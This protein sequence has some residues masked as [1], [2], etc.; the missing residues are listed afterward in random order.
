MG[1]HTKP[2]T[3]RPVEERF[4]EK[5]ITSET[6]SWDGTPCLEWTVMRLKD[7]YG[8]FRLDGKMQLS[9]RVAMML[10]G[11]EIGELQVLHRCDNPPC[12]NTDHLFLGTNADNMADMIAK[13]RSARGEKHG[14][15]TKPERTPRGL[16]NGNTKQPTPENIAM[17]AK[18]FALRLSRMSQQEISSEVGLSQPHVGLILNGKAWAHVP[19]T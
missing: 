14:S 5:T 10:A 7:G 12:V 11:V 18:I 9:H 15:R 4:L 8:Q 2:R 16:T 17:K 13:G 19:I 1:K 6:R 3:Q